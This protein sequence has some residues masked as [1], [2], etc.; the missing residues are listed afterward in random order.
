M[1]KFIKSTLIKL[2]S[3]S[4]VIMPLGKVYGQEKSSESRLEPK[5]SLNFFGNIEQSGKKPLYGE[6]VLCPEVS[7]KYG[8]H[9]LG[10]NGTFWQYGYT[11][12][13]VSE[14]WRLQ[15][16]LGYENSQ[17]FI[18]FG[19]VCIREYAGTVS[20]PVTPSFDN[21]SAGKG[22]GLQFSGL[23]G[24][25]RPSGFGLGLVSSNNQVHPKYWDMGLLTWTKQVSPEW[26]VQGHI[27]GNKHEISRSGLTVKW[28][29]NKKFTSVGEIIYK[30]KS[31]SGILTSQYQLT[32][33]LR[34]YGGV[35]TSVP[36]KGKLNGQLST[37]LEY[38]IGNSGLY[39]FGGV[40]QEIG[41]RR[42]TSGIIGLRWKG[43]IELNR[44]GGRYRSL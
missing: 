14:W 6:T 17:G 34:V 27:A 2:L 7:V 32:D 8:E 3:L 1:K 42:E 24:M 38:R 12:G 5:V 20:C 15:S 30:N 23:Y 40:Q 13:Q 10:F 4:A 31:T 26:S 36:S 29:P 39:L 43:G 22:S 9:K 11:D 16:Y 28:Q 21:L 18:K 44:D 33:S 25:H 37:G 41:G 35:L 19:R